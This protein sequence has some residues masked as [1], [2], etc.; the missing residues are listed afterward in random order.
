MPTSILHI[1]AVCLVAKLC[2]TLCDPMDC[3]P[4]GF[5][6][7]GILQERLLEW[8]T[9]PSSK[10][11]SQPRD[12][13]SDLLCL[14]HWQVGSLPLVPPGKPSVAYFDLKNKFLRTN[15]WCRYF[16]YTS[17]SWECAAFIRLRLMYFTVSTTRSEKWNRKSLS[18]VRLSDPMD[19]TVLGIL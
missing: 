13:T 1:C 12:Q 9:M 15:H 7:H 2:L 6:V 14:L 3:S 10:G 4:P 5:S 16:L 11:S 19:C 18:C 17:Y 8:V